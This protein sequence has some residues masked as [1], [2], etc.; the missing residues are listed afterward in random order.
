MTSMHYGSREFL[1]GL[2]REANIVEEIVRDVADACKIAGFSIFTLASEEV[3]IKILAE[4]LYLTLQEAASLRRVAAARLRGEN[5]KPANQQSPINTKP[6]FSKMVSVH[7]VASH[8]DICYHNQR[9]TASGESYPGCDGE[10]KRITTSSYGSADFACQLV[11]FMS[12]CDSSLCNFYEDSPKDHFTNPVPRRTTAGKGPKPLSSLK[13]SDDGD[14]LTDSNLA[15]HE[16]NCRPFVPPL[17]LEMVGLS[18]GPPNFVCPSYDSLDSLSVAELEQ[19]ADLPVDHPHYR[20]ARSYDEDPERNGLRFGAHINPLKL[21]TEREPFV[22]PSHY[23]PSY[24]NVSHNLHKTT[25]AFEASKRALKE[26]Q[27]K[28]ARMSMLEKERP[29]SKAKAK[30]KKSKHL[31]SSLLKPTKATMARVEETKGR[32][33]E[34]M[35]L[36]KG[37]KRHNSI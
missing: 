8:S 32:N 24:R 13:K 19:M 3:A 7:V 33:P 27:E 2:L 23:V 29:S 21:K 11:D 31:T 17:Q 16:N 25:A 14:S 35:V 6:D 18:F 30:T 9:A 4:R 34:R 26:H 15:E 12:D 22:I 20:K 36:H 37:A 1:I 28:K 10:K 5:F